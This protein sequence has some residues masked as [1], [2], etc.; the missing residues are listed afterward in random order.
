MFVFNLRATRSSLRC[1]PP[2]F[3]VVVVVCTHRCARAFD[4]S[5]A[6]GSEVG[7]TAGTAAFM[8]PEAARGARYDLKDADSWSPIYFCSSSYSIFFLKLIISF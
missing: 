4:V 8:S 6:G 2:S 1:R 5:S 3:V 7:D